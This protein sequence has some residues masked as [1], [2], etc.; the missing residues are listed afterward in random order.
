MTHDFTV[1]RRYVCSNCF[2]QLT[3]CTCRSLPWNLIQIDEA[4]QDHVRLLNEKGY[5][6]SGSCE[7]H[8]RDGRADLTLQ[9]ILARDSEDVFPPLPEG[10]S[11]HRTQG[12]TS[13]NYTYQCA[14][15][16]PVTEEEFEKEKEYATKT[17]LKWLE[18]LKDH[19]HMVHR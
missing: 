4:I 10:F 18:D 19:P 2:R 5:H 11:F 17:L 8:Y 7:G 6:T 14:K 12:I 16:L 13:I 3:E 9:I 1:Y 15:H